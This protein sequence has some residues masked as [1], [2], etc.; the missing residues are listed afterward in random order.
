MTT[1]T[2]RKKKK[3]NK[4][5]KIKVMANNDFVKYDYMVIAIALKIERNLTPE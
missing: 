4:Q 3:S 5:E 2:E 1:T